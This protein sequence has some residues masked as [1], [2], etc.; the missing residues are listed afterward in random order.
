VKQ[1]TSAPS[2]QPGITDSGSP[3]ATNPQPG[4]YGS[5]GGYG[6]ERELTAEELEEQD[7][8]GIRNE[9][10]QT[11]RDDVAT[12]QRI[13]QLGLNTLQLADSTTRT[14][15]QQ[16]DMLLNTDKNLDTSRIY[17]KIADEKTQE[18]KTLNR[19]MFAVG[20]PFTKS[21]RER[22]AI[23]REVQ[24]HQGNMN[25]QGGTRANGYKV[26]QERRQRDKGFNSPNQAFGVHPPTQREKKYMLE[27]D[28]AEDEELED[29]IAVG[30]GMA[31]GLASELHKRAVAMG[32]AVD[33]Q[34]P[35]IDRLAYKVSLSY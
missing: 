2:Q 30:I 10:L 20:N 23:E 16:E 27:D 6:E 7:L 4:G 28:D 5:S 3:A 21:K 22:Q 33:R 19:S 32:E 35:L 8:Q 9:V 29:E 12:L 34:N 31:S 1:G 26:E 17:T 14:L 11:K 24:N 15:D 18:L 25:I 13:N